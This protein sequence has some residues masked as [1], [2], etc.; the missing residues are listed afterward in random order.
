MAVWYETGNGPV[1]TSFARKD[2]SC[3]AFFCCGGPSLKM[4]NPNLLKGHNR[5]VFGINNTYPFVTPDVWIGMDSPECYYRDVFWQPFVKILRG[6]YQART[7]AGERI[8]HL[9]NMF[10]ADVL[11]PEDPEDIF[12]LRAHDVRF[13]WAKT[14]FVT[15]LHIMIW[16]G[17]KKIYLFGVDFNNSEDQYFTPTKLSDSAKNW[18]TRLYSQLNEYLKWF[19]SIAPVYG[20]SVISCSKGSQINQY[21]PYEDYEGVIKKQ[22]QDLPKTDKLF[23]STEVS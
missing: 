9:H 20:V 18:N 21:L 19:A 22:E 6:G 23:H 13:V 2:N 17:C 4:V 7:C 11:K 14:V 10:Y 15:A 16:M 3:V 12:K 8:D 5:L 1:K